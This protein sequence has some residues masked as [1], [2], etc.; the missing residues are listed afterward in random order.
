VSSKDKG[1]RS[2][3]GRPCENIKYTDINL[4]YHKNIK[5]E[6]A[7]AVGR[8]VDSEKFQTEVPDMSK[9]L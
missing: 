9:A 8:R 5:R 3:H 2:I 4:S 7:D 6:W 1:G